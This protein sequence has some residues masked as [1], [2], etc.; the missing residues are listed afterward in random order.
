ML[1]NSMMLT[2]SRRGTLKPPG[3]YFRQF[4]NSVPHHLLFKVDLTPEL[5]LKFMNKILATYY[6]RTLML[7]E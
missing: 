3:I 5:T 6:F 1:T 7:D 4:A 2:I